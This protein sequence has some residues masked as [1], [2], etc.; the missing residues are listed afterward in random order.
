MSYSPIS[1]SQSLTGRLFKLVF[2][3]YVIL[4]VIVTMIQLSLEYSSVQ[5]TIKEDLISIGQSFNGRITGAMWEMDRP[6]LKT[7]SQGIAQSSIITGVKVS[8]DSGEIFAAIGDV[9]SKELTKK[10]SLL[11]HTQ[12]YTSILQKEGLMGM[13]ELGELT[14]YSNRSIAIDRVTYSFVVILIFVVIHFIKL[15]INH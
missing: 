7:I 11:S 9:P 3:G 15:K 8:S 2:G 14:V 6:L 10:N 5:Q 13:R 12:F 1:F 4:A